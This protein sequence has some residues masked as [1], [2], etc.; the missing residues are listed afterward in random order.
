MKVVILA[1]GKGT[2]MGALTND[3]PKPMIC[4]ASKP[5]L[6]YQVELVKK[7]NLNEVIILS[8]Y[9]AEIIENYFKDGRKW[10]VNIHHNRESVQLGTSGAIK[11]IEDKLSE[12]F[13][14]FYG[15]V[16]MD[17][18]LESLIIFHLSQ[19]PIATIA[20]HPND[21]PYDS[22]LVEVNNK[23]KIV[24]FHAK[25]H[26][27]GLYYSNLVNAALYVLSPSIFRY[28][29]K[30]V[31][32]D[33]GKDIF[34]MLLASGKSIYAYNTPEYI[35]DIGTK[36]RLSEVEQDVLS[37]RVN[38]FNKENKQKAVFLDRDGVLNYEV[39]SLRTPD[40]LRFLPG[41]SDAIK[42][43]N[44]SDYLSIVVTNQPGI[45]KGFVN[46]NDLRKIHAKLE[47]LLGL[48]N[49]YLDRIYYCPHHPEKGFLGEKEEYKIECNC[50][51]P[52]TGMIERATKELNIDNNESFIIGD[53]TVE[54]M[55]GLNAGLNTI[56]LRTGYGGEDR[57]YQC[58]PDFAFENLKEA[59][60][61][62]VDGYNS[63]INIADN[64]LHSYKFKTK[65]VPV[66]TVSGLSRSGKSTFAKIA[67]KVMKNRGILVKNLGLDN[68]LVSADQREPWM[69][70]RERYRYDEII[71]ALQ[72]LLRGGKI[73]INKYDV[74]KRKISNQIETFSLR[75]GEL[76]IIDGI[77][78]LDIK[79]LRDIADL[80]I[81]TEIA[82]ETRKQRF[83]NFYRYKG[84]T[85]NSIEKLYSQRRSDENQI[86]VY[87]KKYA[88]HIIDMETFQ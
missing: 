43:I 63:L 80:K 57:K 75:K 76:L 77:V 53:R 12:D 81:Y 85:E 17:V 26:K 40:E 51:K 49:A 32:S 28:I 79:F 42:K 4:L 58:E 9:K 87:T 71:S 69:T 35:K 61:F 59:I 36:K 14:V 34:P 15:D 20:V 10:G 45:A 11:A 25:P 66:I 73:K 24:A 38:R 33:F 37:G 18:D 72:H 50:R 6:E 78:C 13:L 52:E 60:D 22:D 5:L 70:V 21:H 1:G 82:E 54:I 67:S 46:E 39:D 2:R 68:W 62:L 8:G 55:T 84:L 64:L 74:K 3:V 19:R 44:K 31:Y 65:N 41:V 83:Y 48:N 47:A 16:M 23:N 56:L 30:G 86:V 27:D 29:K 88:D 7:Y